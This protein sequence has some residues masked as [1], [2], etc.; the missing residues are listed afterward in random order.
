MT[1][2]DD[3]ASII[4]AWIPVIRIERVPRDLQ[5]AV[6]RRLIQKI[7]R[8]DPRRPR[9]ARRGRPAK[10]KQESNAETET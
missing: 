4:N 3:D 10:P 2:D 8:A 5:L 7:E 9:R 1:D 6:L